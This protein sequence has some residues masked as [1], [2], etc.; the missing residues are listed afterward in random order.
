VSEPLQA[1]IRY[2]L[3][4]AQKSLNDAR[5]LADAE[6]WNTCVTRPPTGVQ[7]PHNLAEELC[8]MTV[9]Q[10][11]ILMEEVTDLL[12]L[13]EARAQDERFEHNWAWFEAHA[14]EIYAAHRGKCVCIAGGELFV[15][16]TPEEALAL[17]SAAHPDD[18]GRFTRLIPQERMPR[19]YADQWHVAW[20]DDGLIRPVIHAEIQARD[21]SWIKAPL[22]LDTGADRT[23]FSTDILT[24]LRLQPVVAETRLG[25][26]GGVAS[27]ILVET[28]IRLTYENHKTSQ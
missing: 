16:D 13:N 22:L 7:C 8:G 17:A 4:R 14:A 20:C 5:L 2:R 28:R 10:S 1:L 21:G 9:K 3:E 18:N 6:S 24:A 11:R 25:G 26:V 19:V 15:A 23:V 27:A 12:E